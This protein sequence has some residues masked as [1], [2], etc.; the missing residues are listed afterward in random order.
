MQL[1]RVLDP[2]RKGLARALAMEAKEKD[3][4]MAWE[5]GASLCSSRARSRGRAGGEGWGSCKICPEGLCVMEGALPRHRG[6]LQSGGELGPDWAEV[7]AASPL[8][9]HC[10][11][12]GTE[13]L[14]L[15]W[16]TCFTSHEMGH[17]L[18][19]RA[20]FAPRAAA[21]SA[22]P[23]AHVCACPSCPR[24]VAP[25]QDFHHIRVSVSVRVL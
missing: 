6:M 5:A 7:L 22:H 25:Q 19:A 8:P 23:E 1:Q 3:T 24:A 11:R 4:T 18:Q 20:M 9:C 21:L 14:L 16:V 15:A 2:L 12:G 10:P 17:T 13:P